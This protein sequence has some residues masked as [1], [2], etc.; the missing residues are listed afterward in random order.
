MRLAVF[1]SGGGS[2]LQV[3]LDAP[4]T[5][6]VVLVISD[7][8]SAG[9]LQRAVE[10]GIAVAVIS[11]AEHPDF[12]QAL[13]DT[14][15]EYEVEAIALAGYLRHIPDVVVQ[16]YRNRILNIH[17]SLLP[18]F[19]GKGLYGRRVHQAVLDYGAK[20]TGA[21]VH[22]VDETY[23]TG[24]IVL[25]KAV[26]VFPDDTAESLAE[27]VLAVEHRIYPEAVQLLVAD[28]LRVEDRRVTILPPKKLFD[29]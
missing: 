7:R 15:V 14:L 2:N 12:G 19:G 22:F 5:G 21:T 11:P 28:R 23:D 1:A 9:A 18:A 6:H 26:P 13:L 4:N 10:R 17:P 8:H 25:Q 3:L 29:V 27:R 20:V 24:P 16:A